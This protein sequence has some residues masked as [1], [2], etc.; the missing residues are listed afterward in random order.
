VIIALCADV[1]VAKREGTKVVVEEAVLEI[2]EVNVVVV[3][4][5]MSRRSRI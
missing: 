5:P 3:G 1:E 4:S 2:A